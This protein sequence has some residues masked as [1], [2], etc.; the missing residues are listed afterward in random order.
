[1]GACSA[2]K[3]RANKA[4]IHY[5]CKLLQQG[6]GGT[7]VGVSLPPGKS[8]RFLYLFTGQNPY[9]NTIVI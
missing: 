6:S 7:V 8:L 4:I 1:V 3:G 2:T 9:S 5:N